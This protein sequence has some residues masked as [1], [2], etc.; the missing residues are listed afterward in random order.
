MCLD[1]KIDVWICQFNN[2]QTA[3]NGVF[4]FFVALLW[5]EKLIAAVNCVP[6]SSNWNS[7]LSFFEIK[8][9]F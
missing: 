5:V 3:L 8:N 1:G 2:V 9:I 4:D 7:L 6:F